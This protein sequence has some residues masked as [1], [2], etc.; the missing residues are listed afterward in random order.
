M[1][2]YCY[3]SPHVGTLYAVCRAVQSN[4]LAAAQMKKQRGSSLDLG[5]LTQSETRLAGGLLEYHYYLF[6]GQRQVKAAG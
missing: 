3:S 2:R 6:C 1:Y 4:L 5:H